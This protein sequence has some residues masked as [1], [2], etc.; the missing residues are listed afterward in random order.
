MR[1]AEKQSL[2]TATS[3]G[4]SKERNDA[5]YLPQH[6]S[7]RGGSRGLR[8]QLDAISG[9]EVLLDVPNTRYF[10]TAFELYGQSFFWHS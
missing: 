10:G 8:L 1:I 5:W 7:L 9:L 6:N 2:C 3:R 4:R